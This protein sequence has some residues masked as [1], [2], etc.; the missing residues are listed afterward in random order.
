L[1]RVLVIA[2]V[3][4]SLVLAASSLAGNAVVN[5]H[6]AAPS[7]SNNLGATGSPPSKPA[8]GTLPFTGLDLAGI[9]GIAVLL[10]GGGL[11]LARTSRKAR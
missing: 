11:I 5:G 8:A 3:V 10:I 7:A 4:A 9:T 6:N 1:K 2:A